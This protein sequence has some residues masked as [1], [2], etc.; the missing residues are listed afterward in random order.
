VDAVG[1]V[2]V[3]AGKVALAYVH[4][5]EVS[6][7][8]HDS[9]VRTLMWDLNH[10]QRIVNGGARILKYSSA[11]I[12]NARNALVRTFLDQTQAEWLWMVDTDMQWEPED[13]D[14]LLEVADPVKAPI[15]GAL[16]FGIEDG[17]L[18]PTLYAWHKDEETDQIRIG[19]YVEFPED[20]MFQV[21]ATGAAFLL[22]HRTVLE[23]IRDK[24]FNG[25]F[26]WFQE[27]EMGGKGCGEDVTFCAR[28]G[29][30]QFPVWVHTGVKVGHHKSYVLTADMYAEQREKR[31]QEVP[32]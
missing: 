8:F 25:T 1:E 13:L 11:N 10:E 15:V 6:V 20:A 27:T 16:C 12:S 17:L 9:V 4:P 14:A 19:R 29:L 2:S 28:A 3:G 7:Y 32:A 18:F 22:I 31:R 23:A 26:P 21:G 5:A 24:G 30:L